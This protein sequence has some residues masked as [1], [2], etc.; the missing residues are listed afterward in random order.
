ME[1]E[2]RFSG[3]CQR[4]HELCKHRER[5][6]RYRFDLR[7]DLVGHSK[8]PKRERIGRTVDQQFSIRNLYPA[9]ISISHLKVAGREEERKDL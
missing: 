5:N 8:L 6:Q 4:G 7:L 3:A 9:G 1:G 2:A